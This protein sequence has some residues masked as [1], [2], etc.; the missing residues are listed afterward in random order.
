[1]SYKEELSSNA[2]KS[3]N[4]FQQESLQ[5]DTKI[6]DNAYTNNNIFKAQ[7]ALNA[8]KNYENFKATMLAKSVGEVYYAAYK[9]RFYT[10]LHEYLGS[11]DNDLEE[12]V[13]EY[14][15]GEGQG[16]IDYLYDCYISNEYSSINNWDEMTGFVNGEYDFLHETEDE[17][18]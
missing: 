17:M 1:M 7:L 3:F 2:E 11:L 15:C 4:E 14:F 5:S 16:I 8:D 12:N 13:C 9:I 18:A 10:S 6:F